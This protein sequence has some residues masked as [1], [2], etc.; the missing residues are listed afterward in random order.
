V[1]DIERAIKFYNAVFHFDFDKKTIAYR[2][3]GDSHKLN[4]RIIAAAS[5]KKGSHTGQASNSSTFQIRCNAP[6][7]IHHPLV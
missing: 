3:L 5:V 2:K 4:H 1:T 7:H 6:T